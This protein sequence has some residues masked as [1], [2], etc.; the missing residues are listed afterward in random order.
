MSASQQRLGLVFA[1]LCAL[2]GAFVPAIAKLTT[3]AGS[4]LFVAMAT[5]GFAGAFGLVVLL[6]R[7][8]AHLLFRRSTVLRLIA[9]GTLGTG[10]AF[11]LFFIGAQHTTPIESVLCLQIE[12]LYALLAAWT[13]LGHRPTPRRVVAISA[14]L[15]GIFLAVGGSGL[16]PSFG[17]WML[18]ITPLCWQMSHLIVLRGLRGVTPPALTAARYI[19]GTMFLLLCWLIVE[20]PQTLPP[21]ADLGLPLLALQG[22]VLSYGGTLVWYQAT[23]RLDLTRSTAIV[24]PSTPI[25]SLG[26]TFLLTGDSPTPPQ[27]LGMLL[28]GIGVV[29]FVTAPDVGVG[30]H[31]RK[32]SPPLEEAGELLP[33]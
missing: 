2:N 4:A 16:V 12:P 28:V 5:S 7:G 18:L 25:L 20:G 9:T 33:H 6:L 8:E 17:V 21:S 32:G 24:V 29:I 10:F 1:A 14:L 19:F 3:N 22:V 11:L 13:F 27:W 23:T 30:R 31:Q 15:L 26:A